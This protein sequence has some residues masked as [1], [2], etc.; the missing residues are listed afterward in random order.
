MIRFK[1]AYEL[2]KQQVSIRERKWCSLMGVLH[3]SVISLILSWSPTKTHPFPQPHPKLLICCHSLF[4]LV[5]H[6]SYIYPYTCLLINLLLFPLLPVFLPSCLYPH[7]RLI[8]LGLIIGSSLSFIPRPQL[9]PNWLL[10]PTPW[11]FLLIPWSR[12]VPGSIFSRIFPALPFSLTFTIIVNICHQPCRVPIGV[13]ISSPLCCCW[14]F[15]TPSLMLASPRPL[16]VFL[17]LH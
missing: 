10:L 7:H 15:L 12:H 6:T 5:G 1:I 3:S 4:T 2:G 13:G 14:P 9:I 11:A 8:S 17:D 16:N